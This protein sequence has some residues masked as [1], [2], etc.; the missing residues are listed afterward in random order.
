MLLLIR[1]IFVSKKPQN[2]CAIN[3]VSYY[4]YESPFFPA[5]IIHTHTHISV[6]MYRSNLLR[7]QLK[8]LHAHSK[9]KAQLLLVMAHSHPIY[10]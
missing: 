6:K 7:I 5:S 9:S 3:I 8:L 2:Y 1:I 4:S 10:G